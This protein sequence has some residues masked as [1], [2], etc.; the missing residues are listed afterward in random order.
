MDVKEPASAAA[1]ELQ[2]RVE[3]LESLLEAEKT[4]N[5]LLLE[6]EHKKHQQAPTTTRSLIT[7]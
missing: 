4:N 7:Y 2:H 1:A 3:Q 5:A 6:A